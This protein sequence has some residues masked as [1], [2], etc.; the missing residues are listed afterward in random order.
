VPVLGTVTL[1][2]TPQQ[3][4][5]AR[6]A[7]VVFGGGVVALVAAYALT[8]TLQDQGVR[9]AQALLSGQSL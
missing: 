8:V 2:Q 7:T 3:R 6:V 4:L 1:V 5:T 9:L